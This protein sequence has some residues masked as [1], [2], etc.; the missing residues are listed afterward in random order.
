LIRNR[1]RLAPEQHLK[2]QLQHGLNVGSANA[3]ATGASSDRHAARG[4]GRQCAALPY[5]VGDGLEILLITSRGAGRWVLPK[6]WPMKGKTAHGAA[7]REALEEAGVKGEVGR[8][9]IGCY[10]YGKRLSNGA[11]LACTVE[12]YPLAVERQLKRWPEQG[13]RTLGWFSA[14]EAAERVEEAELT[15]LIRSFAEAMA[16]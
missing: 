9:A 6:G 2:Y 1:I 8:I 4:A 5:R 15:A 7:A 3:S 12:V 16:A 10:T 13:Q 14:T 11:R